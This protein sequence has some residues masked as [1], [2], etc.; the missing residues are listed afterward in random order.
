MAIVFQILLTFGA[1]CSIFIV[2][3]A[4]RKPILI[5]G[6]VLL[7]I[8]LGCFVAFSAKFEQTGDQSIPQTIDANSSVGKQWSRHGHGLHSNL[9]MLLPSLSTQ[10]KFFQHVHEPGDSL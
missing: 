10:L 8:V 2:D 6:F 9:W 1:R 3:R 7:T 5:T 4:G